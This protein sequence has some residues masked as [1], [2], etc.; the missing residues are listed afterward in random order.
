[1][2][3]LFEYTPKFIREQHERRLVHQGSWS[4][5]EWQP[6]SATKP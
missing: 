1:M 4:F 6:K 3:A 5:Y 2:W